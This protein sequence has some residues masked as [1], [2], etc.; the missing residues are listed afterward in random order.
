MPGAAPSAVAGANA[1]ATIAAATAPALPA[2][3]ASPSEGAESTPTAVAG[4]PVNATGEAAGGGAA[5]TGGG[6]GSNDSG[7][8]GS[9]DEARASGASGSPV[10][11]APP[12][13]AGTNAAPAAAAV[14][15]AA[16]AATTATVGSDPAG[17]TEADSRTVAA[18][19]AGGGPAATPPTPAAAGP[20]P[21]PNA[22]APLQTAAAPA[23][24]VVAFTGPTVQAATAGARASAIEALVHLGT[25]RGQAAARIALAPE[26]LGGIQVTLTFGADGVAARLLADRPEAAAALTRASHDL[27]DSLQRQGI[28]LASLETGFSGGGMTGQGQGQRATWTPTASGG[29]R[30]IS[31]SDFEDDAALHVSVTASPAA[32]SLNPGQLVDLRA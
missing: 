32:P 23:P 15:A 22:P 4:M 7:T 26:T 25:H 18:A 10:A 28:E 11:G 6:A 8:G 12:A 3:A 20:A 9:A 21:A 16:P 14:A 5:T 29:S 30:P 17:Q 2:A 31:L 13:P 19:P 27:R 24:A 1:E